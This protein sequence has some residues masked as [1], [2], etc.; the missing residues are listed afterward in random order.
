MFGAT[1][2]AG[3]R[4]VDDGVLARADAAETVFHTLTQGLRP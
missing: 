3:A 1:V 4:A 2:I